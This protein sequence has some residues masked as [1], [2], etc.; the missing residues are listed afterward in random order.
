MYEDAMQPAPRDARHQGGASLDVRAELL[1]DAAGGCGA[2]ETSSESV[3]NAHLNTALAC[4]H[5]DAICSVTAGML[6]RATDVS[7]SS[8]TRS[9]KP[10]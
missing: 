5:V 1:S 3:R 2:E 7:Q 4:V 6:L 9:P 10:C 8:L